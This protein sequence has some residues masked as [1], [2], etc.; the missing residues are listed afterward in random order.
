MSYGGELVRED[1]TAFY[2]DGS[3]PMTLIRIQGFSA[4][5]TENSGNGSSIGLDAVGASPFLYFIRFDQDDGWGYQETANGINTI[6]VGAFSSGTVSGQIYVFGFQIQPV[7]AYGIAIFNESGQ[8]VMTNETQPLRGVNVVTPSGPP[9]TSQYLNEV[10]PGRMAIIPGRTGAEIYSQVIGGRPVVQIITYS[11]GC[12]FD[13]AN[14][15][16]RVRPMGRSSPA[17]SLNS[18]QGNGYAPA[19]IDTTPYG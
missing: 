8:C 16:I 14:S 17:I 1:G 18:S 3:L 10:V 7:P 12:Y 6:I 11:T 2:I 13:G 9:A 15:F 5:A 19:Y 4:N